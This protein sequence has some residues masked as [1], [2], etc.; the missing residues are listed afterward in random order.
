MNNRVDE[1]LFA[2][3]IEYYNGTGIPDPNHY[4]QRF[5]FMMRAFLHNKRM[6]DMG[7]IAKWPQ[8]Q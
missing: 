2:E 4:P 5:A 3:F 6:K 8:K 1:K 7:K